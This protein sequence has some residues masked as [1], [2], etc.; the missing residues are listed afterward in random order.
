MGQILI[1]GLDDQLMKRLRARAREN[2]RSL[3]AEVRVILEQAARV[4][5]EAALKL[6][7]DIRKCFEG[8]K[9]ADSANLIRED[10]GGC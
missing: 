10:R 2:G 7:A 8:R 9:L 4:D 1:H 5:M 6:A 3:Q